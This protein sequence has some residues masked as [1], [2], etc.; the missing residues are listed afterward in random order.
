[1]AN[2]EEE[3]KEEESALDR[4]EYTDVRTCKLMMTLAVSIAT[5]HNTHRFLNRCALKK[6]VW[7]KEDCP[8]IHNSQS[9]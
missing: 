3:E 8:C 6:V 7:R 1:M 2:T 9:D 5:D 4:K